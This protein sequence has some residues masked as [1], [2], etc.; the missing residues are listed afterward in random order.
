M[1]SAMGRSSSFSADVA[2]RTLDVNFIEYLDK[3]MHECMIQKEVDLLAYF[4][5]RT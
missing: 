4:P 5:A 2:I 1:Q 3:M